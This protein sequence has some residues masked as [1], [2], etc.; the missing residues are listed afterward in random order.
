M[1]DLKGHNTFPQFLGPRMSGFQCCPGHDQCK[2]LTTIPAGDIAF[3]NM[4]TDKFADG[5]KHGITGVMTV[6]IIEAFEM[7]DI[8]H[9]NSDRGS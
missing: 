1:G 4:T 7:I 3:P 2:L 8:D 5:L 6:G 9:D